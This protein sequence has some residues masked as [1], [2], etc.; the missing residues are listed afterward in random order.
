MSQMPQRLRDAAAGLGGERVTLQGLA[1]AHGPS[2]R[3]TLLVLLGALCFLPVP[4]G[5]RCS[6]SE[7]S[8]C[9]S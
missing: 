1:N 9:R 8:A 7:S 4:G 2:T 6:V 5:E 3:E